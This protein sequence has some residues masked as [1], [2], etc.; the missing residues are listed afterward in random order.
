MR[1]YRPGE[2]DVR[3]T[4]TDAEWWKSNVPAVEKRMPIFWIVHATHHNVAC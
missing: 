2:G 3:V 1:A 4:G